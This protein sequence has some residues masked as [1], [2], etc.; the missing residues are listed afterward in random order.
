MASE[1]GANNNPAQQSALMTQ[2]LVIS[3]ME[4]Q[5]LSLRSE[6]DSLRTLTTNQSSQ[7]ADLQNQIATLHTTINEKEE[8]TDEARRSEREGK[9]KGESVTIE[10]QTEKE[11]SVKLFSDLDNL[12]EE[13]SALQEQN[14]VLKKENATLQS[15]NHMESST[16]IP[17]KYEMERLRKELDCVKNHST[18]MEEELNIRND[19]VSSLK[20]ESSER[21]QLMRS[22]MHTVTLERDGLKGKVKSLS[23]IK[24]RLENELDRV[25]IEM[26]EKGRESADA[27]LTAEE[28][29]MA[30]RRMVSLY[31]EKCDE[32]ESA[33]KERTRELGGFRGMVQEI[34]ADRDIARSELKKLR[35]VLEQNG[36]E[37]EKEINVLKEK[38][39]QNDKDRKKL[40]GQLNDSV[41]LRKSRASASAIV[42]V[43]GERSLVS[44]PHVDDEIPLTLT[45][46]FDR[47]AAT[48]DALTNEKTERRRVELYLKKLQVEIEGKAPLLLQQRKDYEKALDD[49]DRTRERLT[50]ALNEAK[51]ARA[52][53]ENMNDEKEDLKR[54][55][56]ELRRETVDLAG[57]VQ[58]LL[59]AQISQDDTSEPATDDLISVTSIQDLQSQNQRL[60][61][62]F[63]S[64]QSERDS[65]KEEL[66][67]SNLQ[68]ALT[69]AETDL[70]RLHEERDHQ[71]KIVAG[72]VQ[73]RDLY[74]ALLYQSD[75]E[76]LN[77]AES[78]QRALVL[79]DDVKKI[80]DLNEQVTSLRSSLLV[81]ENE[82][83]SLKERLERIDAHATQLSTSVDSLQRQ[84]SS[85]NASLTRTEADGTYHKEKCARLSTSVENLR[86]ELADTNNSISEINQVNAQLQTHLSQAQVS[87]SKSEKE[88]KSLQVKMRFLESQLDTVKSNETRVLNDNQGLRQ[89]LSRQHTLLSS[90]QKIEAS[91]EAKSNEDKALLKEEIESLKSRLEN[92]QNKHE[93][94]IETL[95]TKLTNA[96]LTLAEMRSE[97]DGAKEESIK[98]QTH[99]LSLKSQLNS[100][101][102]TVLT[103]EK[104]LSLAKEQLGS[105]DQ[106]DKQR[107][108][109]LTKSFKEARSEISDLKKRT[110]NYQTIA[111]TAEDTLQEMN[112]ASELY[113]QQAQNDI[114][115]LK[116]DL[117]KSKQEI[118]LKQSALLELGNDL[119]MQKS[120]AKKDLKVLENDLGNAKNELTNT[121]SQSTLLQKRVEELTAEMT[122]YQKEA[123]QAQLNYDRELTLHATARSE[124]RQIKSNGDDEKR[125]R[126]A[127]QENLETIKEELDS[128]KKAWEEDKTHRENEVKSM[129]DQWADS[130]KQNDLLQ[131]QMESLVKSVEKTKEERVVEMSTT[132][133]VMDETEMTAMKKS[134]SEL[135]EIVSYMRSERE[136]LEAQLESA[137]RSVERERATAIITKRSLD[138]AR[139]ELNIALEKEKS[140]TGKTKAASLEDEKLKEQLVLLRESNMLLREESD[141]KAAHLAAKEKS[142]NELKM[143]LEPKE[144]EMRQLE[145]EKASL[146]SE[147]ESLGREVE[148]WKKRVQNLL[149]KFQQIDPE[150]HAALQKRA[151]KLST[152]LD[153]LTAEKSKSDVE[154]ASTKTVISRLN[155][156]MSQQKTQLDA[157]TK[158]L[159]KSASENRKS[160]E[161]ANVA[162]E[163]DELS[164]KVTKLEG[165]LE[166]SK[167][168]LKSTKQRVDNLRGMLQ[169]YKAYIEDLKKKQHVTQEALREKEEEVQHMKEQDDKTASGEDEKPG[170]TNEGLTPPLLP[171]APPVAEKESTAT[172]TASTT[173]TTVNIEVPEGGFK[174]G[175]S[176]KAD[177]ATKMEV[178]PTITS[179]APTTNKAGFKFGIGK[180]ADATTKTE[181]GPTIA[182]ASPTTNTELTTTTMNTTPTEPIHS[183]TKDTMTSTPAAAPLS[184][185]P[186]TAT[187]LSPKRENSL[188]AKLMSRK[189]RLEE[190][191]NRLEKVKSGASQAAAAGVAAAATNNNNTNKPTFESATT[192]PPPPKRQAGSA[193][194]PGNI[195]PAPS[196]DEATLI[197]KSNISAFP[198][199]TTTSTTEDKKPE[200][201]E[202]KK[203]ETIATLSVPKPPISKSNPMTKSFFKSSATSGTNTPSAFLNLT[204][205]TN[206]ASAVFGASSFSAPKFTFGSKP[207][208]QL[209]MPGK[210]QM[211]TGTTPQFS[212]FGSVNKSVVSQGGMS[213][214][215][216]AAKPLFGKKETS[217]EEGEMKGN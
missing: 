160:E 158:K 135:R 134:V 206:S 48:E 192:I 143:Q 145:V 9:A 97:R 214:E 122:N 13:L 110:A 47:M 140:S 73:Q 23:G 132:N 131:S 181:V 8:A 11:K 39:K 35:D 111:K 37:F 203:D 95:E 116:A 78:S 53:V 59:K 104:D 210:Q 100:T 125:Q 165:E 77:N 102:E 152:D 56:E 52:E 185:K 76:L 209:P 182:S 25:A 142:I 195:T 3:D 150:E 87:A 49:R 5:Y 54:E 118:E 40:E 69:K 199:A 51:Y 141:R 171:Q 123:Q 119:A 213:G 216:P 136:I 217:G 161:L 197:V 155:A 65:L 57:Q 29:V 88:A 133:D 62:E 19:E 153:L 63:R 21:L 15:T 4:S 177:A 207:T 79:K 94:N 72:I 115:K 188:R 202:T 38:L 17:L 67:K 193:I 85:A 1:D 121:Q 82:N 60:L 113:K 163:K 129:E 173:S 12:R 146:Q 10:L 191:M 92:N 31:K 204:P 86:K 36:R 174:F 151:E 179:I 108:A 196:K 139:A 93:K 178:I 80:K 183:T 30:E 50:E 27:L 74:R 33:L 16:Q 71:A 105:G 26:R 159:A 68:T 130:R 154:L 81:A 55:N 7:I 148:D 96:E 61:R 162:K 169:K 109:T 24:E 212:I 168:E 200:V 170:S 157:I 64:V 180:K 120:E 6:R 45:E 184:P 107:I 90:I 127:L 83:T 138:E 91:L 128:V 189:R 211:A 84:L 201:P 198:A 137:K 156:Q 101:K 42:P 89:E 20:L 166:S 75:S 205:P 194:T 117:A 144:R 164:A 124:L 106:T 98:N 58:S 114:A 41:L 147:K 46:V 44:R 190:E 66:S 167:T 175:P 28:E 18:W 176:K 99:V 126:L 43:E 172:A 112:Q 103:L 149:N 186:S 14:T 32:M 70:A 22:E 2:K 187:P 215:V 34:S 208:I